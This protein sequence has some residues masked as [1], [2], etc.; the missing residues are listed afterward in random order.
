[1][2]NAP[3]M[4]APS[5]P[6]QLA[7]IVESERLRADVAGAAIAAFNREGLLYASGFGY[8]DLARAEV[9]SPTTLF[10]AA[11]ITKLFTTTLVLQEVE[12]GRISLDQPANSY[13]DDRARLLNKRGNQADTVT[14]RHLLTH[15]SGLPVSWR[16]IEYGPLPYKLLVN[17]FQPPRD[18][19]DLVSG[20]RTVRAPGKRIVYSNGGFELLGYLVQTVVGEPYG[21]L[22]RKRV[23]APLQMTS[24]CLAVDPEG[25]GI[26][27]SYGGLIGG[28]GRRPAPRV[29]NYTGPAGALVTSAVELANFGRMVLRG[30]EFNGHSLISEAALA[31]ALTMQARN[32]PDLD[33]GLGLGFWVSSF[34]SRRLVGH[35]GG[36]SGVSTRIAMLPD[37]GVGA[38][39]LANGANPAFVHRAAHLTL[40]AILGLEPELGP[41]AP[42]GMSPGSEGA[43]KA[44]AERASGR[45][46]LTNMAPPGPLSGLMGL[47]ARPRV[48][49][50]ANGVLAVEGTGFEP[51]FLFPDR[52]LG[53]YRVAFAMS[54][55]TRA[56]VEERPS[57]THIWVSIQ[58][59][60]KRQ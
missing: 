60:Q 1:M 34:R 35:D 57:G 7:A 6:D 30:G 55:G 3:A 19:V 28:A 42:G 43:W 53:R 5:I 32:H 12:A 18:L 27:T 38:I 21:T 56:V 41:G 29:T 26:A 58:H 24:S 45:Y 37:D 16:G 50:V 31:E 9:V 15:T 39:V 44:L 2:T 33:E 52:V 10:R 20:Q 25:P 54:S 47:A 4:S 23:L 17:G 59:L 22:L 51:A 49:H 40:E 13:L 8:A 11:S 46:R 48:S 36:L 14:V